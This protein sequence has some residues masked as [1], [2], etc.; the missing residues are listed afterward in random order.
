MP[1][2]ESLRRTAFLGSRISDHISETPEGF[3]ICHSARLCRSGHQVYSG[4]EIGLATKIESASF[5][6]AKKSSLHRLSRA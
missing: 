5:A 6:H 3:L 4:R 1:V 2:A